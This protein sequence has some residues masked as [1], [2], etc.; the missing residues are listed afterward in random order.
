VKGTVSYGY[1]SCSAE[2][3]PEMWGA[4]P[5]Q[6]TLAWPTGPRLS[7]FTLGLFKHNVNIFSKEISVTVCSL[8][9]KSM[10]FCRSAHLS[11][12]NLMEIK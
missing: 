9:E 1:Q 4:A 5:P 11:S 8:A 2:V 7:Q 6:A 10:L 3:Q 12:N